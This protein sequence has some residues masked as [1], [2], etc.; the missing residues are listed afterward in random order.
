MG[1]VV[2][3]KKTNPYGTTS[4]YVTVPGSTVNTVLGGDDSLSITLKNTAGTGTINWK[5]IATND[6]L[7]P[8]V[9]INPAVHA[10]VE[11]KA[12]ATLASGAATGYEEDVTGYRHYAVQAKD[13]TGPATV[14][15]NLL[16][17]G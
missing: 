13:S 3:S 8:G 11:V 15:A 16:V 10:T 12:E 1:V 2:D 7:A 17:K 6:D 9:D 5:V 4:A 14:V